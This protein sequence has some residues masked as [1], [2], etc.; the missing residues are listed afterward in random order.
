MDR[1]FERS[2]GNPMFVEELLGADDLGGAAGAS[3]STSAALRALV[4]GRVGRL[5]PPARAAIEALAIIGRPADEQLVGAVAGLDDEAV[6]AALSDAIRG[7]VAATS[8]QRFDVRHP[9][10]GE[11]VAGSLSGS[12]ARRL[13][14]RAADALDG[15]DDAG[16]GRR[17]R[18]ASVGRG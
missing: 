7:G 1:L 4:L 2:A 14:R 13:H 5:P 12:A 9:I 3:S 8:G 6:G 15:I 17:A 11:V 10:V 16:H 18:T